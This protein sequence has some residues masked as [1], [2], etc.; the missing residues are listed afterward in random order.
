M[1]SWFL[2]TFCRKRLLLENILLE[3]RRIH[4]H[5]DR[6]E[7]FYKMVNN[8]KEDSKSGAWIEEGKK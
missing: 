3:L 1:R 6:M 4:Y 7:A 5:L 2:R 8:I